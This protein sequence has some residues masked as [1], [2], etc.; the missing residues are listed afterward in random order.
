MTLFNVTEI[1]FLA[2]ATLCIAISAFILPGEFISLSY[3]FVF[4]NWDFVLQCYFINCN[5]DYNNSLHNYIFLCN[6]NFLRLQ[7]FVS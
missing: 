1:V 6:L 7:I 4:C 2:I 3:S 5:F